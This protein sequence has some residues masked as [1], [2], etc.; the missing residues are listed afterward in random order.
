M[1]KIGFVLALVLT[2]AMLTAMTGPAFAE[3]SGAGF[4]EGSAAGSYDGSLFTAGGSVDSSA[5]GKG[6]QFAAASAFCL[7]SMFVTAYLLLNE[8]D[9]KA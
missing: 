3:T 4:A 8:R 7:A 9:V 6:V 2:L 5:Q 1:K